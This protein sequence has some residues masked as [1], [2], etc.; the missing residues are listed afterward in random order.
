MIYELARELR[1]ALAKRKCPLSVVDG[2]EATRTTTFARERVV[3]E[4]DEDVGDS[5]GAT[6]GLGGRAHQVRFTVESGIKIT[7]YAQ[8]SSAGAKPFEHR[9]RAIKARDAVM[10]SLEE[11]ARARVNRVQFTSGRFVRPE[12]LAASETIGGAVYELKCAIQRSVMDSSWDGEQTPTFEIVD[13]SI[14]HSA[15]VSVNGGTPEQGC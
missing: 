7:I 5:F 13:G 10:V 2:D 8:S 3:I 9:N 12:D 6:V 4:F 11:V 1:T 14:G 15:V